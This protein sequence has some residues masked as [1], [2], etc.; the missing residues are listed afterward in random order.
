MAETP[1][2]VDSLMTALRVM[3]K[4]AIERS[5]MDANPALGI[6]RI[7]DNKGGALP[8]TSEDLQQYR[9]TYPFST[10]T[11]LCLTLL[12]FTACRIGDAKILGRQHEFERD[13]ML[14]F[15]W[16]PQKRDPPISRSLCL[17]YRH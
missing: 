11:Y 3:F 2:A 9:Q 5:Y 7:D 14:S 8:W 13:G 6:A 17:C 1:A 12:M 15:G 10:T 16:P 4:W